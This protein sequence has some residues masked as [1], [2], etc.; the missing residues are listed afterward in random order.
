M[1]R[2]RSELSQMDVEVK[3]T[4]QEKEKLAQEKLVQKQ[5]THQ[6]L[7]RLEQQKRLLSCKNYDHPVF[8]SPP[9]YPGT[10]HRQVAPQR[11]QAVDEVLDLTLS[12]C[13]SPEPKLNGV[14]GGSGLNG[15]VAMNGGFGIHRA[16]GLKI[17]E[18]FHL[19]ELIS[20]EQQ[21]DRHA[22]LQQGVTHG[23]LRPSLAQ[24]N[25]LALA[26]QLKSSPQTIHTLKQQHTALGVLQQRAHAASMF[27]PQDSGQAAARFNSQ[28]LRVPKNESKLLLQLKPHANMLNNHTVHGNQL[29]QRTDAMPHASHSLLPSSLQQGSHQ[30][31]GLHTHT[32]RVHTHMLERQLPANEH[33]PLSL[34]SCQQV[35]SSQSA[36]ESSATSQD[37]FDFNF[38]TSPLPY[39]FSSP[40]PEA[41]PSSRS[42]SCTSPSALSLFS[43]NLPSSSL[44][45]SISSSSLFAPPAERPPH[46]LVNGH[47]SMDAHEALDLM[48]HGA[49]A[50]RRQ[51][52][53][54]YKPLDWDS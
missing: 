37:D 30:H 45:D 7:L 46:Q 22:P 42:F 25:F 40:A 19:E 23:S 36:H 28:M 54:Q 27:N 6:L 35:I 16:G 32:P 4:R 11:S 3:R 33:A 18:T 53:I 10:R 38:R 13:S 17:P 48:T 15:T 49:S 34:K 29:H 12:P 9:P 5:R 26:Q 31:A 44:S 47:C 1:E 52:V 50:D 41:P 43:S 39:S 8:S 14:N 2:V 51:S 21:R 24:S 20:Q